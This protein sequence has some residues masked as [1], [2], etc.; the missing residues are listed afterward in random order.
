MNLRQCAAR[1]VAFGGRLGLVFIEDQQYLSNVYICQ[2]VKWES[3]NEDQ[4]GSRSIGVIDVCTAELSA[5]PLHHN[6]VQ[7]FVLLA[8]APTPEPLASGAVVR[9]SIVYT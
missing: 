8:T 7:C 6:L 9:S 2:V 1:S 3:K 4:S 5:L